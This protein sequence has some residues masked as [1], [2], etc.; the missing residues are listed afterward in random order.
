MIDLNRFSMCA[1]MA[2]AIVAAG[3]PFSGNVS[4]GSL[5]DPTSVRF[6]QTGLTAQQITAGQ[7]AVNAFDWSDAAYTTW[8]NTSARTSAVSLATDPGAPSKLDRAVL[9]AILNN[10]VAA[11]NTLREWDV[12]LKAAIAAA[13]SLAN[14]QTRVAAL[15]N[16]PDLSV[17][18]AITAVKADVVSQINAGNAD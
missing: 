11:L 5:G 4:I 12:S 7:N 17:S 18:A 15:P 1:R 13:T 2:D 14:L 3:C 10:A 9:I 8:A 6:D 16:L